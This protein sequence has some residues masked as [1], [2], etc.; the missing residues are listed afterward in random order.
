[1]PFTLTVFHHYFVNTLPDGFYMDFE[2]HN[3]FLWTALFHDFSAMITRCGPVKLIMF[4]KYSRNG[5]W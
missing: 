4:T 1:M 5:C 3:D 2:R